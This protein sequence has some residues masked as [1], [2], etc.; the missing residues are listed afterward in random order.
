MKIKLGKSKITTTSAK[1]GYDV[2]TTA[3]FGHCQPIMVKEMVPETKYNVEVDTFVRCLPLV[4][5]TFGRIKHKVWHTFVPIAD[6]YEPFEN[7]LAA[8]DFYSIGNENYIPT[9]V[10]NMTLGDLSKIIYNL[11]FCCSVYSGGTG[12]RY[13]NYEVEGFINTGDI[14]LVSSGDTNGQLRGVVSRTGT[15]WYVPNVWPSYTSSSDHTSV[16]STLGSG[17]FSVVL[18]TNDSAA[19][20]QD[21]YKCCGT[22]SDYDQLWIRR[23]GATDYYYFQKLS[24]RQ[25]RIRK[26]LLGAGYQLDATSEVRV[27]LL[28]LVAFYKAWFDTLVPERNSITW[29]DTS[30]YK[31]LKYVADQ[32]RGN[33]DTIFNDDEFMIP[34]VDFLIDLADTYYFDDADYYTAHIK[35]TSDLSANVTV[36]YVDYNGGEVS[37]GQGSIG[38]EYLGDTILTTQPRLQSPDN[39]SNVQL[40]LLNI[41]TKFVNK[42]T[43]IGGKIAEY[44]RVHYGAEV[45]GA[46]LKSNFIGGDSVDVQISDVMAN[47]AADNQPLADYAGKGVGYKD[48]S[49]FS[50]RANTFGYWVAFSAVIPDSKF[51]QGINP[52]LLHKTRFEFFNPEFDAIGFQASPKAIMNNNEGAFI[53]PY[54]SGKTDSDLLFGYIP[55]YSEYKTSTKNIVNGDMSLPSVRSSMAQYNLDKMLTPVQSTYSTQS[56]DS[57]GNFTV[58]RYMNS[59]LFA[60]PYLREIGASPALGNFNRIFF[61]NDPQLFAS[62]SWGDWSNPSVLRLLQEFNVPD[63][64]FILHNIINIDASLPMIPIAESFET[65]GNSD[66]AIT[67]DKA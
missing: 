24:A 53:Q 40:K 5:P 49:N 23:S 13:T 17:K 36:P 10:P 33:V 48:G 54:L 38:T 56:G 25:K 4:S 3:S 37:V 15:P 55:R 31:F 46:F 35:S 27:S 34:F 1:L 29:T 30:A 26:A 7:L 51:F 52:E 9:V 32:G 44:L 19:A 57:V 64:N 18:K 63:D 65:D 22:P 12:T 42:N 20:I 67:V 14:S 16:Y 28:P 21:V 58:I 50:F 66:D 47:T 2:N 59:S 60:D 62:G 43:I 11:D 8:K 61:Y 41:L 6:L 45:E 39:I